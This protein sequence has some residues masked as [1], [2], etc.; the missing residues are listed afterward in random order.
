M[1]TASA[2][3]PSTRFEI[4]PYGF[5]DI[6]LID[7]ALRLRL[8]LQDDLEMARGFG[9]A[10]RGEA[11]APEDRSWSS[12]DRARPRPNHL[13][14]RNSPVDAIVANTLVPKSLSARLS[15]YPPGHARKIPQVVAASRGLDVLEHQ[16]GDDQVEALRA[17]RRPVVDESIGRF[18]R[19]RAAPLDHRRQIEPGHVPGDPLEKGERPADIIA[20]SSTLPVADGSCI[21]GTYGVNGFPSLNPVRMC[22]RKSSASLIAQSRTSSRVQPF[23]GRPRK[24]SRSNRAPDRGRGSAA[25]RDRAPQSPRARGRPCGRAGTRGREASSALRSCTS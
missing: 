16:H 3:T 1:A 25:R 11:A 8:R 21:V 9:C 10:N 15:R 12:P 23:G 22:S 20:K 19:E 24:S 14:P 7:S 17:N 13:P 5:D 4:G 6:P 18:G 2:M